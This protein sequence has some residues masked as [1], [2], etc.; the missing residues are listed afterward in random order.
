MSKDKRF[1]P[2][3]LLEMSL[4]LHLDNGET[5]ACRILDSNAPFTEASINDSI[6]CAK[7]QLFH[8]LTSSIS[9]AEERSNNDSG[10]GSRPNGG[11]K[12]RPVLRLVGDR[13]E[14]NVRRGKD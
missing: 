10:R 11:S 7:I 1:S 13:A 6:E 3:T 12:R 9:R 5:V 14:S 2:I 4:F 8:N